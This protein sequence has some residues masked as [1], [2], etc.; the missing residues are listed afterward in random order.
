MTPRQRGGR[1]RG[2]VG[3]NHMQLLCGRSGIHIESQCRGAHFFRMET[4]LL[5]MAA[6]VVLVFYALCN[7]GYWLM[8]GVATATV[9]VS[10][11]AFAEGVWPIGAI[12]AAWA[13]V[14]ARQWWHLLKP[15]QR[16][17]Y[18]RGS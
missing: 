5:L 9:S 14:V 13:I 6:T 16:S 10:I 15:F 12:E 8:L 7:R 1:E 3:E 17:M 2:S 18:R 4:L 11:Y